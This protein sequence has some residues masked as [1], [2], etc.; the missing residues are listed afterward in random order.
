MLEIESCYHISSAEKSGVCWGA[1]ITKGSEGITVDGENIKAGKFPVLF[2]GYTKS[3]RKQQRTIQ[4][5][6]R[7][8]KRVNR[9]MKQSSSLLKRSSVNQGTSPSE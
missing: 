5:N 6:S 1:G 2:Y 9:A 7:I 4:N 8:L 3:Q